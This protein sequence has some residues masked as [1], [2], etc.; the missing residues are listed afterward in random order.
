MEVRI[1]DTVRFFYSTLVANVFFTCLL[2]KFAWKQFFFLYHKKMHTIFSESNNFNLC[3]CFQN[4]LRLRKKTYQ[5][6]FSK[7]MACVW[8]CFTFYLF[9]VSCVSLIVLSCDILCEGFM[10]YL[11][12]HIILGY[13]FWRFIYIVIIFSFLLCLK[14]K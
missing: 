14:Q 1:V 12:T 2:F 11:Y 8:D 3:H 4:I 7:C 5:L 13:P 6:F 9:C 10:L